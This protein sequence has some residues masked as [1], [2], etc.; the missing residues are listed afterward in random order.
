MNL[1][2]YCTVALSFLLRDLSPAADQPVYVGVDNCKTC[3]R[4]RIRV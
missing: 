3:H 4:F 2:F 1:K